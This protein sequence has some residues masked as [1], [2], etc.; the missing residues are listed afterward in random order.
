MKRIFRT[1]LDFWLEELRVN[2]RVIL[3]T[4]TPGVG[5]T[6]VLAKTLVSLNVMHYTVGGM[7]SREIRQNEIRVGFEIVDLTSSQHG[8]L[9]HIDHK[10][11]PKVGKYHVHL[12]NLDRIGAQA[13]NDAIQTCQ[14][15]AIDEIGPMELFSTEF[16]HA[17]RKALSSSKLII[18]VVHW[19]AQDKLI[20]EAKSR[21][22]A[23]IITVT[24]ENRDTLERL[25]TEKAVISL[26][27]QN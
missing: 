15:I 9:A 2:K 7:I 11:G 12:E 19:K 8:W 5:K 17:V 23:E 6:T 10:V 13:I 1:I 26:G 21:Q 20:T 25:I 16:K 14:I 22:D 18:A 4:G 27:P 24:P 3:L